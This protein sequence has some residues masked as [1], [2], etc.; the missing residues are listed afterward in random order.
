MRLRVC[1][2]ALVAVSL[3]PV[4]MVAAEAQKFPT[5]PVR[6]IA[7]SGAGG[8]SD[9]FMRALGEEL[10]KKWGQPI[11]VENRPGG[12][13]NIGVRACSEA[14]P[15]GYTIC[16]MGSTA[17]TYNP[18]L[19]RKLPFDYKTAVVPVT[20]LFIITQALGVNAKLGV[21]TFDQLVDYAKKNPGKLSYIA[22][23]T[24]QT[25]FMDN[26]N[27]QR[28]TDWVRVPFRGGGDTM[29]AVVA[30]STPIAFLG[31]GNQLSF[32]DAKSVV[33][34]LVDSEKRSPLLPDVQTID[35]IGYDGPMTRGSFGLY[36]P[37]GTPKA[38]IDQIAAD[39]RAAASKPEFVAKNY[40]ARALEPVL[41]SPEEFARFI[42]KDRIA[43]GRV[44]KDAGVKPYD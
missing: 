38:I 11:I 17:L 34:V 6:V 2:S 36:A 40:R 39:V 19:F 30:G 12:H 8:L 13:F 44:I 43:A 37:P 23:S 3:L 33:P 24:P 21:K 42:E 4:T 41:D 32:I 18:Y 35:E 7:S 10:H 9:V 1:L 14:E 27:K 28:G 26:M 20:N 5:K 22:P 31:L 29:G 16:I 25:L 15:D